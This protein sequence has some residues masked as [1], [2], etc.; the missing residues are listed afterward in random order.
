MANYDELHKA[1]LD[2]CAAELE[3]SRVF[4]EKRL[5]VEEAATVFD[6]AHVAAVKAR[7]DLVTFV[8]SAQPEIPSVS[9]YD[10]LR[11]LKK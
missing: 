2:A 10:A 1:Y 8:M 3:A 9:Y 4:E 11:Y 6:A 7:K 5:I